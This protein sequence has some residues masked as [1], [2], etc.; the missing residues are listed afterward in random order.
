MKGALFQVNPP[1]VTIE[2]ITPEKAETWLAAASPN[3]RMRR[4]K[5]D[6]FKRDMLAGQWRLTGDAVVLALNGTGEE[7]PFN[8]QH[9]LTAIVESGCVIQ[10]IVLRGVSYEEVMPVM[11]SGT[12]RT[13]SDVLRLQG[14]SHASLLAGIVSRAYE[15]EN[16]LAKHMGSTPFSHA[17]LSAFLGNNPD[18]RDTLSLAQ[19]TTRQVPLIPSS[20]GVAA[21]FGRKIDAE[22]T[23]AFFEAVASGEHLEKG[24]PAFMLRQWAFKARATS[25]A[26]SPLVKFAVVNRALIATLTGESL[27][28]LKYRPGWNFPYVQDVE[29]VEVTAGE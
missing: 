28:N 13:L 5:I 22:T 20:V 29:F 4:R 1:Q 8:G 7:H 27:G 21:F 3:R 15:Q 23:D 2:W 11:D 9:R 12:K 17:E 6:Q 14:E 16:R 26:P 10:Q 24:D 18:L 19:S 25:R